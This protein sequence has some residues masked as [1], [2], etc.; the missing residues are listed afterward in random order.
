MNNRILITGATDGIGKE[1]ALEMAGMGYT[2]ILHGRNPSKLADTKAGILGSYPSASLETIIA[3]FS[4]LQQINNMAAEMNERFPG[5]DVLVNN[6]GVYMRKRV[7][8]QDGFEL[9]F[10]VNYLATFSLTMQLL[11]LL[12]K[13]P[14]AKIINMGSVGHR[15]VWVNPLD[16]ESKHFFWSWVNYCRSKLLII[17]FTFKLAEELKN[18][19]IT[20]NALHPGVIRG[21]Q[22]TSTAFIPSGLPLSYG[23]KTLVNLITNPELEGLSGHYI[24]RFKISRPSPIAMN[25]RLRG[26]LWQKSFRWAGLNQKEYECLLTGLNQNVQ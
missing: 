7:T 1:T 16:I 17:P 3:D 22:I 25:M 11:P 26:S 20:I 2:V 24:E 18:K 13:S 6:A 10:A 19:H 9:T 21:T 5:L 8:S 23:V 4:S 12:A 14:S 15:Y